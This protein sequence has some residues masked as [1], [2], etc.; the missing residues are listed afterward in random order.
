MSLVSLLRDWHL[1]DTTRPVT[2]PKLLNA[3]GQPVQTLAE[4]HAT[5]K[6]TPATPEGIPMAN[7]FTTIFSW[8]ANGEKVIYA[9]IL[10]YVPPVAKLAEMLFPGEAAAIAAGTSAA[11]D[12]TTLIQNAVLMVEQKYAASGVANGTGVA[13]AAEV[14]ALAGSAVTSLLKN[15]GI[16]ATADY[17]QSLIDAVVGILNVQQIAVPA[18]T[19]AAA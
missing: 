16:T 3:L 8:I 17:L 10:K 13:K 7:L 15:L 12:V 4:I 5:P 14:T 2:T 1:H 6:E 11:L 18:T 19:P 9:D